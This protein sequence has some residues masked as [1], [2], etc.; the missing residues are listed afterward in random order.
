M[1]S[2]AIGYV[3]V[4]GKTL[5]ASTI[6]V[7]VQSPETSPNI[8][9]R[10][11]FAYRGP[12]TTEGHNIP[13]VTGIVYVLEAIFVA[14]L[15]PTVPSPTNATLRGQVQE[16]LHHGYEDEQGPCGYGTPNIATLIEYPI[17]ELTGIGQGKGYLERIPTIHQRIE[18]PRKELQGE[19]MQELAH[20]S[21]RLIH[22][23]GQHLD[24]AAVHLTPTPLP[25]HATAATAS[26]QVR[27]TARLALEPR[28]RWKAGHRIRAIDVRSAATGIHLGLAV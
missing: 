7:V 10:R 11:R 24:H 20:P 19:L 27:T 18:N 2:I 4:R 6:L 23:L 5:E 26:F 3:L 16:V 14:L 25:R 12:S 9:I 22:H 1:R 15:A 17:V 28:K 8:L 21:G 13:A